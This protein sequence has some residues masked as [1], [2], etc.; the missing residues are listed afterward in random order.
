MRKLIILFIML[1][2]SSKNYSEEPSHTAFKI[3]DSVVREIDRLDCMTEDER[4]V[5]DAVFSL[6]EEANKTKEFILI[7]IGCDC[8]PSFAARANGARE[9]AFPFDWCF[10]PYASLK[11]FLITDFKDYFK[12]ENFVPSRQMYFDNIIRNFLAL[13][14]YVPVSEYYTWVLDKKH[15][16][17]YLHDFTDNS[18]H[19]IEREYDALHA[20][21][22][23]RVQRFYEQI[24]SGKHVYFIRWRAITKAES[25]ELFDILKKKFP[26]IRFTL[27]VIN[28]NY[29]EFN[30]DWNIPLI[31]NYY[32]TTPQSFDWKKLYGDMV[33]GA[34]R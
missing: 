14:G 4:T 29:H 5:H 11:H 18:P 13:E 30:N 12:K 28:N 19:S 32:G 24:Y 25:L 8:M 31:K 16:M 23:R 26:D 21:Y 22:M 1:F 20:K 33:A 2:L 9:Y 6:E 7:P 15:S 27:I 3:K 17:I 10:T 34:L